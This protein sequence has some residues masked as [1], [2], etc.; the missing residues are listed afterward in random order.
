MKLGKLLLATFLFIGAASFAQEDAE[1]ECLRMRKFAQDELK[2]K[3]YNG[4]VKYYIMGEKLCNGY[5]AANY[6]RLIGSIRNAINGTQD[7]AEKMAYID[8]V[9][10]TYNRSELAG[11]YENKNDLLRASYILQSSNPDRNKADEL[12]RR[13]IDTQGVATGEG[14]VSYFYYNTYAM[15]AAA[16]ADQKAD[17]KKRMITEYFELSNLIS[18]A[19]MS[20]KTQETI[21]G[22]FNAVVKDCKDIL[23]ELNEYMENL[24]EDPELKKAALMNFITLLE[25]KDC[26]DAPEYGTLINK[27]VE[28]DPT[29]LDAQLMKAKYLSSKGKSSEAIKTLKTAKGIATDPANKQEI[30]YQIASAQ[31]KARSYTAAYNTAMSVTG[32]HRGNALAIA[33]KSVGSNANN[34]GSSTFDR[35]CNYIYAVQLLEQA[36]SL[37]GNVGGSISSYKGQY[38]TSDDCFQNGNPGSVTLTCYGVTVKPCN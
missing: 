15:F 30:S 34:C 19:N 2:I 8:T 4:A 5:D 23:P 38:P 32:E 1:L 11:F 22:Y 28:T 7:K 29:S 35:K 33:G 18:T 17:L 26:T 3:N 20:V 13:G 36:R 9:V 10:A 37:G 14:Y 16:P 24:P 25:K 31:F 12:F 21:T 27:Y 6:K